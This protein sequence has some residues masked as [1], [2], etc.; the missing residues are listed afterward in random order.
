MA[1]YYNAIY[2]GIVDYRG[3]CGFLERVLRIHHEGSKVQ[4]ILDVGCGTGS[5]A[6]ILAEKGYEVTGIDVSRA[7]IK[8]AMLQKN[9]MKNP[10]F[11]EMDMRRVDLPQS[12]KKPFDVIVSFFG[13]FGYLLRDIDVESFFSSVK[14]NMSKDGLLFFE[15]WQSSGV[16]PEAKR[17]RGSGAGLK[18][19]IGGE[20]GT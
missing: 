13:G 3:D 10:R 18:Q 6:F 19:M 14:R 16:G 17:L 12:V 20:V 1:P 8:I 2:R 9:K 15:F 7:M 11:F 4:S 5:H